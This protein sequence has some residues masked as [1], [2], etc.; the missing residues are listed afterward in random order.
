MT[1]MELRRFAIRNRTRIR[2]TVAPAAECLV[3]E[4]GIVKIPALRGIPDFNVERG[5]GQVEQ[6]TLEPAEQP[7]RPQKLSRQQ[8]E[9][10]L[11]RGSKPDQSAPE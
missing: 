10:L 11:G 9:A 6:F 8:L 7:A 5:L 3:N 1:L 2:F 4:H